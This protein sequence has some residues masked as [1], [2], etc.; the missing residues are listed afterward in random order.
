M[1]N[2]IVKKAMI[3]NDQDSMQLLSKHIALWVRNELEDLH[4]N[5]SCMDQETMPE[6]NTRIRSGIYKALFTLAN[7]TT[8][9]DCLRLSQHAHQM[10]P[11]Y[12]EEPE[13]GSLLENDLKLLRTTQLKFE[14][15][16]LN[17]QLNIGN[18]YRLPDSLYVRTK[19]ASELMDMD[20]Q[21]RK[22]N[23]S[24]ISSHLRNEGYVYDPC[25]DAYIKPLNENESTK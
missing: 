16:F 24:K 8:N 1:M 11:D 17:E 15:T 19:N 14:S 6:I 2:N 12:W 21:Q 22:K 10:I 20:S 13:L 25:S 23:L 18:I 7:S 3:Y 4:A 9:Y 5:S